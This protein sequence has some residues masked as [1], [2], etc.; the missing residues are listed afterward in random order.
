MTALTP[1][2]S[3]LDGDVHDNEGISSSVSA[4]V[5]FYGPIEFY[6]MDEEFKL[7]G[8]DGTSYSQENS[9][10]SKFLGQAVGKD[11]AVTYRTYWETYR[12]FLPEDFSVKAWIQAGTGDYSVPCI[13]SENLATRLASLIETKNICFSTIEGAKHMDSAFYTDENLSAVF[14]FLN[15][16]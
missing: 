8:K 7:L 13:Q 9:F 12:K 3:E 14:A 2:V 15:E 1:E 5:D 16:L 11:K 10:E 4:V 6:T